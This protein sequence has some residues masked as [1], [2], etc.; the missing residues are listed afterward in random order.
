MHCILSYYH[1]LKVKRL[2]R[3]GSTAVDAERLQSFL[4]GCIEALRRPRPARLSRNILSRI[5]EL[6]LGEDRII[7][8]IRQLANSGEFFLKSDDIL[9]AIDRVDLRRRQKALE[10]DKFPATA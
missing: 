3:E 7:M 4:D 9:E 10:P 5:T 2:L 6:P 1:T 8:K